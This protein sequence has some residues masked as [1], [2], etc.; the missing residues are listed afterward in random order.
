M[1]GQWIDGLTDEQRD[2]IVEGRDWYWAGWFRAR[3]P[4]GS[5][6]CL[7]NHAISRGTM[8]NAVAM[9][10]EPFI[11]DRYDRLTIR[12]GLARVVRAI[13]LRAARNSTEAIAK[14]LAPAEHVTA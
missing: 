5:G 1:I 4:A 3:R 10:G 14:L 9:A 2:N 7:V 6:S 13:K 12:F 8:G 11:A